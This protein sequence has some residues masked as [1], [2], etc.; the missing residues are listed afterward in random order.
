[1][2]AITEHPVA[3]C[4]AAV[5]G[6]VT[7]CSLVAYTWVIPT[8]TASL[9]HSIEVHKEELATKEKE[10]SILEKDK[11]VL[12]MQTSSLQSRIAD[13]TDQ[14]E[15]LRVEKDASVATLKADLFASQKVNLFTPN[16]PYPFGLDKIRVGDPVDKIAA[17]YPFESDAGKSYISVKLPNDIFTKVGFSYGRKKTDGKVEAVTFD[18]GRTLTALHPQLPT[19]PEGWLEQTLRRTLGDPKVIGP[20]EDCLVWLPKKPSPI[21]YYTKGDTRYFIS[22][23]LAPGGCY[24]TDEQR[25]KEAEAK[26]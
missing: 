6:T 16:D 10:A 25:E 22:E 7:I 2:P 17:A 26:P 8:I 24:V 15:K 13:L 9:A 1:M 12:K 5:A 3:V 11:A 21:V 14:L 23:A 20:E 19:I 18:L 4:A